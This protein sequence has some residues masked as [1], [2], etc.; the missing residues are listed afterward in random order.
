[1]L[2]Q[3][4]ML[5]WAEDKL[6]YNEMNFGMN[7]GVHKFRSYFF[8]TKY[9][10]LRAN[11]LPKRLRE[12]APGLMRLNLMKILPQVQDQLLNLVDLWLSAVWK[13]P[14][15][16][17]TSQQ[18]NDKSRPQL[19]PQTSI[20]KVCPNSCQKGKSACLWSK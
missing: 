10:T 12:M 6:V 19:D 8:S 17:V 2:L 1:M 15:K 18:V 14:D 4:T 7:L 3:A 13:S 20:N 5:L 9:N 16:Y 11:L